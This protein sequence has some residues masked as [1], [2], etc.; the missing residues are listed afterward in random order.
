M[1]PKHK[2]QY[3]II[4]VMFSSFFLTGAS[5]SLTD[6]ST[7]YFPN[8]NQIRAGDWTFDLDIKNPE[9]S[10]TG[11]ILTYQ[12]YE[13]NASHPI[14]SFSCLDI[15]IGTG[16]AMEDPSKYNF[17]YS[18]GDRYVNVTYT[19]FG[20]L[21][22]GKAGALGNVH[23]IARTQVI[24][25]EIK[26]IINGSIIELSGYLVDVNGH[27]S[28]VPHLQWLTGLQFGDEQ[29]EIL[30]ISD[31]VPMDASLVDVVTISV[32]TGALVTCLV[33][34]IAMHY[35]AKKNCKIESGSSKKIG[36]LPSKK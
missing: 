35:R 36:A 24:L 14:N 13:I 31:T 3:V 26:S 30:V 18:W 19:D 4:T 32:L 27:N 2:W 15:L 29:C 9:W 10:V 34:I 7:Y 20:D 28:T 5:A 8:D 11:R 1:I 23:C 12:F 25:N 6:F 17:K 16:T 33:V 21:G 22:I